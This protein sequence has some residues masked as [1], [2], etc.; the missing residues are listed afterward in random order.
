VTPIS[1]EHCS[2]LQQSLLR[3]KLSILLLLLTPQQQRIPVFLVGLTTFKIAP[4]RGKSQWHLIDGSLS[5][6][7][8]AR[9]PRWNSINNKVQTRK[10]FHGDCMK[11]YVKYSVEFSWHVNGEKHYENPMEIPRDFTKTLWYPMEYLWK[12]SHVFSMEFH[13]A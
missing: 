1:G 3:T 11:F 2:R 7:A 13:G 4:S 8:S 6:Q 10:I 9:K 5:P 12:I